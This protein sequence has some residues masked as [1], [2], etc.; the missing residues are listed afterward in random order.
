[1]MFIM[2]QALLS[3][4]SWALHSVCIVVSH[5]FLQPW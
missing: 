1:M 5:Y 2:L 4:H 3:Q